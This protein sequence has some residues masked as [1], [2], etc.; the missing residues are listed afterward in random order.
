MSA[1][2]FIS[3]SVPWTEKISE[4][5]EKLG[6][7]RGEHTTPD[8]LHMTLLF[9]G[10]RCDVTKARKAID[11]IRSGPVEAR[12]DKLSEYFDNRYKHALVLMD[13]RNGAKHIHDQLKRRLGDKSAS[14]YAGH[15][16]M[17]K[18]ND[19]TTI[20]SINAI[21][22]RLT[23]ISLMRATERGGISCY[24]TLY[25]RSLDRFEDTVLKAVE[26]IKSLRISGI[27]AAV[28]YGS[29][30]AG[31]IKQ[32]VHDIDVYL[33]SKKAA[34]PLDA[35]KNV[36][37]A[38][39]KMSKKRT[40]KNLIVTFWPVG[41]GKIFEGQKK[42]EKDMIGIEVFPLAR[43]SDYYLSQEDITERDLKVLFGDTSFLKKRTSPIEN[44][45][46]ACM[47]RYIAAQLELP[48][49]DKDSYFYQLVFS[50]MIGRHYA[51]SK[52]E[53]LGII[54]K[55]FPGSAKDPAKLYEAITGIHG[56]AEQ[57]L[58]EYPEFVLRGKRNFVLFTDANNPRYEKTGKEYF[59]HSY[60]MPNLLILHEMPKEL[61][62]IYAYPAQQKDFA[63][64]NPFL[65]RLM[66]QDISVGN[67][68]LLYFNPFSLTA[69]QTTLKALWL[70][71]D[72]E[73]EPFIF[74]YASLAT[75]FQ[76]AFAYLLTKGVHETAPARVAEH[77]KGHGFDMGDVLWAVQSQKVTDVEKLYE[78]ACRF[79]DRLTETVMK[80]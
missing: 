70:N 79:I 17:L 67:K 4:I 25:S 13:S 43:C 76:C 28:L 78:Q 26:D 68:E 30:A 63:K 53:A 74:W 44:A 36:K 46:E 9:L 49:V 29:T 15:V 8:K 42:S 2:Y 10:D 31:S 32:H 5:A 75:M 1:V 16:T 23:K 35:I 73:R 48:K 33:L 41:I 55:R 14:D 65:A 60:H 40:S 71:Y 64:N 38:L 54:K 3:F 7:F 6:H 27:D 34:I 69:A 22:T 37:I 66:G 62:D 80:G 72:I 57:R 56:A 24:E 51:K 50:Y 61:T 45:V 58:V 21:E 77:M 52:N 11:S 19:K 47:S 18:T 59:R 20:P 12:I 39:Q